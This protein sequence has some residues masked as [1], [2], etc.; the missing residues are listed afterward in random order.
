MLLPMRLLE[1]GSCFV[2]LLAL[3]ACATDEPV[4][5]TGSGETGESTDTGETGEPA[6]NPSWRLGWNS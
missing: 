5:D 1:P 4:G 2:S 6:V 3:S